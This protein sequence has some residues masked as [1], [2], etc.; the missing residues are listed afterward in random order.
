M[1][2]VLSNQIRKYRPPGNFASV[3]IHHYTAAKIPLGVGVRFFVGKLVERLYL[4]AA[5][6]RNEVHSRGFNPETNY[7]SISSSLD[8]M[9]KSLGHP[10]QTLNN[11]H[12]IVASFNGFDS[13]SFGDRASVAARLWMEGITAEYFAQSGAIMSLRQNSFTSNY[14]SDSMDDGGV[15]KS[16]SALLSTLFY[17]II[18]INIT[19]DYFHV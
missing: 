13:A 3:Q 4:E 10:I 14:I 7:G 18:I 16:Y 19:N 2:L 12:C 15:S 5:I 8:I 9:R 6:L 1:F 17:K 11:I